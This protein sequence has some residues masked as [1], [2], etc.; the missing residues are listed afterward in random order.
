MQDQMHNKNSVNN[1][2][3]DKT[4]YLMFNFTYDN[5]MIKSRK[6]NIQLV[7]NSQEFV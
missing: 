4:N 3:N 6:S 7:N 1:S 2:I 5:L